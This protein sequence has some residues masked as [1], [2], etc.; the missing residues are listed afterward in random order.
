VSDPSERPDPPAPSASAEGEAAPPPAESEG[1]EAASSEDAPTETAPEPQDAAPTEADPPAEVPAVA[2]TSP[3]TATEPAESAPPE[4]PTAPASDEPAAAKPAPPEEASAPAEDPAPA[5]AE[6]TPAQE[7][8]DEAPPEPTPDDAPVAEGETSA[9][10]P[11]AAVVAGA[12]AAVPV[13]A[14]AAAAAPAAAPAAPDAAAPAAAGA[15]AEAADAKAPEPQ[16]EGFLQGLWKTK[17]T[18]LCVGL[19]VLAFA[20]QGN[21]TPN[22]KPQFPFADSVYLDH[23]GYLYSAIRD[24]NEW[25]RFITG[26]FVAKHGLSALIGAYLLFQLGG[27]MERILGSA[28][29]FPL[30][31]ISGVGGIALA[32]LW[33]PARPSSGPFVV[34]FAL[35]GALP[36]VVLGV[37][38]SVAKTIKLPAVRSAIFSCVLWIAIYWFISFQFG[39]AMNFAGLIGGVLSALVVGFALGLSRRDLVAGLVALVLATGAVAF[40]AVMVCQGKRYLDGELVLRGKPAGSKGPRKGPDKK[41]TA[42]LAKNARQEAEVILDRFGKI[43]YYPETGEQGLD[44]DQAAEV[45]K[46]LVTLDE[47]ADGTSM[48]TTEV[49]DLR[50]RALLLLGRGHEARE[51]S[52]LLV[53]SAPTPWN[54]ALYGAALYASQEYDKALEVFRGL[55][56]ATRTNT[57]MPE[58]HYYTATTLFQLGRDEEAQQ[59]FGAYVSLVSDKEMPEWRQRFVARAKRELGQ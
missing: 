18:L 3:E 25:W 44:N 52:Y 14:G 19:I 10:L 33:F 29:T 32:D 16:E 31:V 35:L 34:G 22:W 1:A 11:A 40:P 38:G 17:V 41:T 27:S 24:S 4:T 43:P 2:E 6:P 23:G 30:I 47:L 53:G 26:V 57:M 39:M 56:Q 21:A 36:G 51:I 37:T 42:K 49:E 59:S 13:V 5:P 46:L 45:G 7:A 48:V 58:V 8:P 28:R 54:K 15:P 12:A 50:A 20:L 9:A 55:L